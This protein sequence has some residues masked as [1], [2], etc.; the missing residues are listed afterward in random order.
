MFSK[1][2]GVREMLSNGIYICQEKNGG[3]KSPWANESIELEENVFMGM[4]DCLAI[5]QSTK[6]E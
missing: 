2:E 3:S 4:K 5:R 6:K 1:Y